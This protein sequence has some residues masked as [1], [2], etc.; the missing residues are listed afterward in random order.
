M[1]SP[2]RM[3]FGVVIFIVFPL[4]VEVVRSVLTSGWGCVAGIGVEPMPSLDSER[5][6]DSWN[7]T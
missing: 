6:F 1:V 7:M 4:P 5:P 2:S 3:P